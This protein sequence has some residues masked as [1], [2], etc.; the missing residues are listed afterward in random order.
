MLALGCTVNSHASGTNVRSESEKIGVEWKSIPG[1]T[2]MMGSAEKPVPGAVEDD[3]PVHRVA[4][5]PFQLAKTLV[6][7]KQYQACVDSGVC[8][9]A[10]YLDGSCLYARIS[11]DFPEA[12]QGP[13][14]PVSC[15]DWEQA[16]VFAEWIGGRLPTEAEWEYAA[17][18]GSAVVATIKCHPNCNDKMSPPDGLHVGTSSLRFPVGL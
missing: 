9:P 13:E 8:L 1:G 7:N 14:Q 16:R 17:R 6:T 2:F 4:I 3:G 10:H 18:G 15:L 5:K 12:F 11:R